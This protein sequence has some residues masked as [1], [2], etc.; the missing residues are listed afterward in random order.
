MQDCKRKGRNRYKVQTGEAHYAAKITQATADKIKE[1]WAVDR[2]HHYG[3]HTTG[4]YSQT[5]IA[6]MLGVSYSTV[7]NIT[8]GRA[9]VKCS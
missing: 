5:Q 3:K 4:K 1:L 8:R 2:V 7:Q 6:S 9:W